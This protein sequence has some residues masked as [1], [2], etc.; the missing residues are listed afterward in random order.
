MVQ[1]TNIG[2]IKAYNEELLNVFYGL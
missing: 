2:G 1:K